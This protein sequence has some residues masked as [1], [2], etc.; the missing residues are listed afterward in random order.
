MPHGGDNMELFMGFTC[1]FEPGVAITKLLMRK[2][3][4]DKGHKGPQGQ[5]PII[6]IMRSE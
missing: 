3:L 1:A 4:R 6:Q 5:Y 2:G